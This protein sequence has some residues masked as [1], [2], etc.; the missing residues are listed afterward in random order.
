MIK[1]NVNAGVIALALMASAGHAAEV[2]SISREVKNEFD[3][4]VS[5]TVYIKCAGVT[6]ERAIERNG[7]KAKWCAEDLP[8][9]CSKQ[10]V[11]AA[12]RVCGTHFERLV[13]EYR[14]EK[15]KQEAL[16]GGH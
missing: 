3:G 8:T 5:W 16:V 2:R 6:E 12:N 4:E 7:K 14:V 9:L 10:K 15:A 13:S 11:K 1:N